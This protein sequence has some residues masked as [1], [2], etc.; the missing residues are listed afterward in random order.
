M[1]DGVGTARDAPAHIEAD[2][3]AFQSRR[4]LERTSHPVCSLSSTSVPRMRLSRFPAVV[5]GPAWAVAVRIVPQQKREM[6][7]LLRYGV[8]L[9]R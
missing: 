9:R 7:M 5:S 1:G 2:E 4:A 8:V 3:D 6:I